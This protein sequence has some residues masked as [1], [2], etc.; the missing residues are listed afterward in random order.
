MNFRK[1]L[2]FVIVILFLILFGSFLVKQN[3]FLNK[4]DKNNIKSVKINE[5]LVKV[6]LA[7]TTE[8]QERGLSVKNSLKDDEGMLFIFLESSKNY[9]WMKDMVFPID[10]IWINDDFR[11][12]HIEKNVGPN[13]YPQTFGPNQES[14][15][16]LEVK[17][18]FSEKNNLKEGDIVEFL[19]S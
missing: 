18:L 5:T 1:N 7:T 15:Y 11:V 9:F 4:M 3:T 13:T 17:A 14:R 16:V 8:E 10:I 2:S 19:A 12:I 6:D